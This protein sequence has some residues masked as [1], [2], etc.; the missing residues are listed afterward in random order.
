[1]LAL[2][3][4]RMSDRN[5]KQVKREILSK[6]TSKN[7][8]LYSTLKL[9]NHSL[10]AKKLREKSIEARNGKLAKLRCERNAYLRRGFY[11]R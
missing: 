1:V 6:K 2:S 4:S 5:Q 9:A 11:S 8:S 3:V 7:T 10:I